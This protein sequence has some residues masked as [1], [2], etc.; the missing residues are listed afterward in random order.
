MSSLALFGV[1][2]YSLEY[3]PQPKSLSLV[4]LTYELCSAQSAKSSGLHAHKHVIKP[5][6]TACWGHAE[7]TQRAISDMTVYQLRLGVESLGEKH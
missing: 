6:A 5:Q 4:Q 7:H 3:P 1:T 2:V